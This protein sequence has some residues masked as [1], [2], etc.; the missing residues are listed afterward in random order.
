MPGTAPA[1]T[2]GSAE[3]S[4]LLDALG[5][6]PR[7]AGGANEAAARAHARAML[8]RDGFTVREEPFEYSAFPGKWATSMGGVAAIIVIWIAGHLGS[9]DRPW[10]ALAVL[11]GGI[12]LIGGAAAWLARRGVLDVSLMRRSGVNLVASRGSE[13]DG[14][15]RGPVS[16]G[17]APMMWLMAHLDSKSQPVPIL[18]RA[19]GIS[20]ASVIVVAAGALSVAQGLGMAGAESWPAL[21]IAATL[22]L[23]PVAASV[24]GAHSDGAIDNASGCAAVLLAARTLPGSQALGVILTSA[25]ELGLAGARA[26]ARRHPPGVC[27]NCDG[28]DD[29]GRWAVMYTGG[30]PHELL[31]AVERASRRI[32]LNVT[33]RRLLPGV[34][35]DGVALADAGWQVITVSHGSLRTL[36]RV[37]TT[38][39]SRALLR[40]D[41][42]TSAAALIATIPGEVC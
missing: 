13:G 37:H 17:A 22:A 25:E 31:A 21:T 3:V 11:A 18:A 12:G 6:R 7:P 28:V 30:R 40:G 26:F 20:V 36:G 15:G 10:F 2:A 41:A 29:E 14:L 1:R 4:E 19:A 42:I 23:L 33:P 16:R 27:V 35:V 32:G 8:E 39:D 9:I 24:V 5:G 38:R 34:L